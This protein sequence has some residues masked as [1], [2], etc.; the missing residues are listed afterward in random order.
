M[1]H[2]VV[3]SL[4][5]TEFPRRCRLS[6]NCA[7][8]WKISF[9]TK[10]ITLLASSAILLG[11]GNLSSMYY[12]GELALVDSHTGYAFPSA[13][14]VPVSATRGE[15]AVSPIEFFGYWAAG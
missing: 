3:T 2:S 5:G 13:T 12:L 7:R 9:S 14:L 6:I 4:V 8:L 11:E 1:L 15:Q 10:L